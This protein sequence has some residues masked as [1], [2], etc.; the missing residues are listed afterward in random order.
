M[1]IEAAGQVDLWNKGGGQVLK[2][3]V[4]RRAAEKELFLT[5]IKVT[6]I[7]EDTELSKAASEIIRSGIT[8]NFNSWK[9]ID[10]INLNNVSSLLTKLGGLDKL[11]ADKVIGDRQLWLTKQYN[12]NHVRALL[13]KY[14]KTLG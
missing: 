13:I 1:Y 7:E 3:L 14:S 10:L 4:R 5:P 11:V 6:I 8:I 12:A 9:R 2:G